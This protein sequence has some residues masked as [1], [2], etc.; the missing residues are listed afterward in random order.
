MKY[1]I[2]IHH[3]I[4]DIVQMTG[5]IDAIITHDESAEIS[6][7]LNRDEYQGLFVNDSRVKHFY[8][9]NMQTMSKWA[10]VRLG[11]RLRSEHFDYLFFSHIS[12]TLYSQILTLVVNPKHAYAEQYYFLSK[13]F[14]KFVLISKEITHRVRR[15]LNLVKFLGYNSQIYSPH[16]KTNQKFLFSFQTKIGNNFPL[17]KIVGVCIGDATSSMYKGEKI[18]PKKWGTQ[19]FSNL[20]KKIVAD[21][22]IVILIGNNLEKSI[23]EGL[24]SNILSNSLV[25]DLV[26]KVQISELSALTQCC[27]CVVGVD[28]GVVHIADAVGTATVSIFGPT[29]PKL[30]GAFSNK[31]IF[32]E[33]DCSCKYC[34]GTD[35]YLSCTD[36]KCL[37]RITVDMVYA[38]IKKSLV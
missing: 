29:D 14:S 11:F 19:N 13:I 7:I 12:S 30:H 10:L 22:N 32:V 17:K 21:D 4:G 20:I 35:K 26:G 28:T 1:L 3:G 5:V 25:V 27:D 23:V 33:T 15:N 36:R 8:F 16:I 18:F 34:Y 9:L 24:D 38:K 6:L 31:A 2:E 37:S